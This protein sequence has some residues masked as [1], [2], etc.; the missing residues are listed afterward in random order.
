MTQLMT[1]QRT[2]LLIQLSLSHDNRR[3]KD[4]INNDN[5]DDEDDDDDIVEYSLADAHPSL[6]ADCPFTF[7]YLSSEDSTREDLSHDADQGLSLPDSSST[8]QGTTHV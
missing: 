1:G 4:D 3:D 6:P 8:R 2:V 5:L 7:L